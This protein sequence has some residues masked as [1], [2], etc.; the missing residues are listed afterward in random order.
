MEKENTNIENP[1]FQMI[2]EL[3][4]LYREVPYVDHSEIDIAG[5]VVD[6][7]YETEIKPVLVENVN[8]VTNSVVEE[9]ALFLSKNLELERNIIP[10]TQTKDY[11]IQF[12]NETLLKAPWVNMIHAWT[13]VLNELNTVSAMQRGEAPIT[14]EL[15]ASI[16]HS[17]YSY[18]TNAEEDKFNRTDSDFLAGKKYVETIRRESGTKYVNPSRLVCVYEMKYILNVIKRSFAKKQGS[19]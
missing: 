7:V 11:P 14:P 1:K 2:E 13:R 5:H 3:A 16:A 15:I 6:L 4:T 12:D 17:L 10:L 19:N 18:T 9:K 8:N